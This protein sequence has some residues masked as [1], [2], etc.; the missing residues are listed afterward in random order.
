MAWVVWLALGVALLV[1]EALSV[2]FVAAYFGVGALGAALCAALGA[3]LWL[4]GVEFIAVSL[5]LLLLTRNLLV[6]MA[7]QPEAQ[8][9]N[10]NALAGRSGIVTIPIDND[11]STGQIRVGGEFWTARRLGEGEPPIPAGA[12]VEVVNVAGVTARVRLRQALE[13]AER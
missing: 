10:V 8:A 11:A 12:K 5:V 6:A 2:S 7:S 9:T 3:P 13:P 4:Q 1:A